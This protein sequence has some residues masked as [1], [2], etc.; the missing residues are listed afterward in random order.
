V[1][2]S[3]LVTAVAAGTAT[4]TASTAWGGFTPPTPTALTVL[5]AGSNLIQ[6]PEFDAGTTPWWTLGDFTGPNNTPG[7]NQ[8]SVVTNANMSGANALLVDV[9]NNNNGGWTLQVKQLLGFRIV[10]GRTYA[11]SVM[12]KAQS[13]RT[14][15]ISIG[16]TSNTE[17]YNSQQNLTTGLQSFNYTWTP[18][19]PN[20]TNETGFNFL[21]LLAKGVVSDVW[22]D[23]VILEDITGIVPVTGVTVTPNPLSITIGATGQLTKT[24]SPA[25]ATNQNVSWVSSNTAVA[26]VN[27]AGLVTG[28]SAGSATIT[29]TTQNS[30]KTATST[31]NVTNI[32]VT[33]VEVNPST[34]S[35]GVGQTGQLTKT[36]TPAN[37]TNQNVNWISSAPAI[38]TVNLSGLVTAV[39]MGQATIT[40]TTVSGGFVD[41]ALITVSEPITGIRLSETDVTI[42]LG[43]EFFH[44][45]AHLRPINATNKDLIWSTS[46]PSI[47]TVTSDPLPGSSTVVIHSAGVVTI[48]ATAVSGGLTAQCVVRIP[49][50]G[51]PVSDALEIAA[52]RDIYN[53][54][55]GA[56]WFVKTN[57]PSTPAQWNSIT[58]V[59]QLQGLHG[60]KIFNGDV[61]I[62]NLGQNNLVGTFPATLSN[63]QNLQRLDLDGNHRIQGQFPEVISSLN[64]L[65]YLDLS[66]CKISGQMPTSIGNLDKLKYLNI[67]LNE[68]SSLPPAF[69]NL[70]DLDELRMYANAF[71]SLPTVVA[72]LTSLKRL[73]AGVL[74]EMTGTLPDLSSLQDLRELDLGFIPELS[75]GPI[76]SWLQSLPHLELLD[77]HETNLTGELPSWLTNSSTLETISLDGNN[78]S[79]ALGYFPNVNTLILSYN[80]FSADLSSWTFSPTI[81]YIDF[82][83]NQFSGIVPLSIFTGEVTSAYLG[84]NQFSALP[85]IPINHT[86]QELDLSDNNFSGPLPSTFGNLTRLTALSLD[87]NEFSGTLPSNISSWLNDCDF[88][89]LGLGD[90]KFTILPSSIW[91]VEENTLVNVGGNEI[92]LLEGPIGPISSNI[93]FYLYEN[94]LTFAELHK[95][96]N[97]SSVTNISYYPQRTAMDPSSISIQVGDDLT[98][99]TVGYT[100]GVDVL[101]EKLDPEGGWL[102]ISDQ[103]ED[104]TGATYH[105]TEG[106]FADAG[107]YRW[108]MTD[109]YAPWLT[110]ISGEITVNVSGELDTSPVNRRFNGLITSVR[111]RTDKVHD[112]TGDGFK[113]MYLY[114]YNDKYQIKDAR[115]TDDYN[116]T[117]GT[118]SLGGSKFRES[119]MTYDPNGNIQTLNRFGPEGF[120][121]DNFS[122][123]YAYNN[124]DSDPTYNN[125]LATVGGRHY[126]YNEVGQMT[127]KYSTDTST[128]QFVEYD[129]AG[130]VVAVFS[131]QGHT[132][133]KVEYLYDDRG[134]RLAKVSYGESETRTT[135]Y[136]RDGSGNVTSVYEQD[137]EADAGNT[138]AVVQ[139]EIPIYGASKLATLYPV[140]DGSTSYE[141]TDHLGNV[142]ALV[143]D[144]IMT[145][146]ATMEDNGNAQDQS[147]PRFQEKVWFKNIEETQKD[148]PNMNHTSTTATVVSNPSRSAYLFWQNGVSGMQASDKATGPTIA[149]EVNEGDVITAEAFA[150]YENKAGD[151]PRN[152]VT[153]SAL[154]SFL[155]NSF[156]T[157][158]GFE[159]L[160]LS[161][162]TQLI[163][164]ALSAGA[165]LDEP[166][167]I[168]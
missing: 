11:I 155:G 21:F 125:Q 84:G 134:F 33:G 45:F 156:Q 38:A 79:G 86:I 151:Y 24:I 107:T 143:R 158:A 168:I 22:I 26:T 100:Q 14:M 54:L 64:N 85:T 162:T 12:A 44:L 141:I 93:S 72:Q 91:D 67:S 132:I 120:I 28:V 63:L 32:A 75:P 149:L 166:T 80:D 154:A 150:R 129:V 109:D 53:N 65:I 102:E 20:I 98:I 146:T 56:S 97:L 82:Y 43:T 121:T 112:A 127:E 29:A 47:A 10:V 59:S 68:F 62:L 6:N 111:W 96:P 60:V 122:Y 133:K 144:D 90:N 13:T 35:L 23:K 36:I 135:W 49:A 92:A 152:G 73:S 131:D 157:L 101:W 103:N 50:L 128:D 3:G 124:P 66:F 40:T 117:L 37:A 87:S 116:E 78:L 27:D 167:S 74:L 76:P 110:I 15:S 39:S 108:T 17:Y 81:Q 57:W 106:A 1:N 123:V 83:G 70:Q 8:Y 153:L 88:C 58:S 142:R 118:Y 2:S 104:E 139:T 159:G 95:I 7:G 137:G 164:N 71:I 42:P 77:L 163:N 119:G 94:F 19:N 140:Q 138:A 61:T 89:Y 148:D 126:T 52:V 30:G 99:P 113:G 114:S 51:P 41:T 105:R 25:N 4:I 147:N 34:L 161:Q 130:K 9:V 165:F 115:W 31:V 16:G 160:P 46:D 55:G 18:S 145:F 5:P 48:T 136:I 69:A